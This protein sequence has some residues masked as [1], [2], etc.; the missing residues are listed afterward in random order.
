MEFSFPIVSMKVWASP[1]KRV[2]MKRTLSLRAMP[3]MMLPTGAPGMSV[4]QVSFFSITSCTAFFFFWA[5]ASFM[6]S[7]GPVQ[8]PS[9]GAASFFG[10]RCDLGFSG[11]GW[12]SG[13]GTLAG[14]GS[15]S[16]SGMG[17]SSGSI[18]GS[19]SGSTCGSGSGCGSGSSCMAGSGSGTVAG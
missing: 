2:F 10:L 12:G 16:G 18:C 17:S 7:T 5:W 8:V 3:L 15:G 9:T 11:A 14:C 6:F 13:S 4:R 19:G 1:L